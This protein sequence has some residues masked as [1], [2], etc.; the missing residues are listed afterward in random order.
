MQRHG[1]LVLGVCQ[2]VLNHEQ[3]AE[4]AFQATFLVLARKAHSIRKQ[5]SLAS[6]LYGVS[7]RLALKLKASAARR[8]ARE[9]RAVMMLPTPSTE[10]AQWQD[11]RPMIDEELQRMPEK[12]RTPLIL[13]YL[14]GKTHLEAAQLLGCPPGSMSKR[15]A[16]AKGILRERLLDRGIALGGAALALSISARAQA[17]VPPMLSSSTAK[18]AV[19]MACGE[20]L[21]GAV[22]TEVANLAEGVVRTMF[23]TK[24]K[25]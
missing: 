20:A 6:W 17:A 1:P 13:C 16:R 18:A 24:L 4:D 15:L 25:I 3:D 19:L 23:L 12:Y 9:R 14:Q 22:S 7:Y 8:R 2:R 21:V 10:D 5:A 11:L